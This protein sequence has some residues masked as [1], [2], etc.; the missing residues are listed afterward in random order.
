[1]ISVRIIALVATG[2]LASGCAIQRQV[3][4]AMVPPGTLRTNHLA[5]TL[6]AHDPV[7]TAAL[8]KLAA[9][10]G[11]SE[12]R[13]LAE[14]YREL[15]IIDTAFDHFAR[16]RE[17]DPTDAVASEAL[18]R[19]WRDWGFP[20]LG[21]ADARRALD[22]APAWPAA[23]NTL[24]TLLAALGRYG[25]AREAYRSALALDRTVPYVWSN[26]C[27]LSFLEGHAVRAVDEC[28][29]ALEL[30]GGLQAARNNLALAYA[31]LGQADLAR[32]TLLSSGDA[33]AGLYNLGVLHLAR[34]E[35][36]AAVEAFTAARR[37]RPT[38]TAA[39][40]RLKQALRAA[41]QS[42]RTAP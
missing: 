24:G 21:L 33:A 14:R 23:H 6:E 41:A 18:A 42:E 19:I 15:G 27:Y 39:R 13:R 31:A 26:V 38:W 37:E 17:L 3:S 1:M 20:D 7:L 30:D 12:H 29:I 2:T 36:A 11:P 25:E 4:P 35:Y 32:Q 5:A 34:A 28:A 9:F 10:E 40:Q 22:A 8:V 16:A